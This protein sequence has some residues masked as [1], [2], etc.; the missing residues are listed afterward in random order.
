MPVLRACWLLALVCFVPAPLLA[1]ST[2]TTKVLRETW[3]ERRCD[4]G[5]L[6][7][8]TLRAEEIEQDGQKLIRTTLRDTMK[9]I[10]SGD[11]YSESTE[12][13]SVEDASGKVVE[14]GYRT[15]LGKKQD[16]IVKGRPQ[17]KTV[18]LQVFDQEGKKV[19][20]E[21]TVPWN[22][23]AIGLYAQDKLL[24]GKQLRPGDKYECHQFSSL[25]NR[26]VPTT[27]TVKGPKSVKFGGQSRELLEVEQTYPKELYLDKEMLWVE[28]ATGKTLRYEQESTL[29]GPVFH[30]VAAEEI[31]KAEFKAKVKDNDSPITVNKKISFKGGSPKELRVKVSMAH[32]DEMGSVFVYDGRQILAKDEKKVVELRLLKK[33]EKEGQDPKPGQDYL[34]S[35]FYIR[36]DSPDVI[37]VAQKAGK[38]ETD[39]R[40]LARKMMFWVRNNVKGDYEVAFATADEVARTLEGDCTEMGVLLAAM[41]RARGIPSRV[42]F[43]LVYDPTNPGFGGHLW[44]EV[45]VDGRWEVMDATGVLSILGA[46]YIKIADFSMADVLNPEELTSVRRAFAH[47]MKVEVLESK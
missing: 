11:P 28:P 37:R 21:Q 6:G 40:A 7:Y 12:Q 32:E 47:K 13:Y 22:P 20:Y 27:F 36:S 1:Q 35:N 29:F 19:V 24:E 46:A 14:V 38:E 18:K 23:A 3:Y 10:R 43:G 25:L 9:Y 15:T 44:T 8:L 41:C 30:E 39:P 31:A 26:V 5:K 4:Q 16:L 2:P 33:A 17:G 34:A 42:A 45:Y